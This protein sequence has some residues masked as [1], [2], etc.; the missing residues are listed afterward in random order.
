[1]T[2]IQ[3]YAPK[4]SAG[5]ARAVTAATFTKFRISQKVLD[6]LAK[7]DVVQGNDDTAR[8]PR[9]RRLVQEYG[10]RQDFI[11]PHRMLTRTC[12]ALEKPAKLYALR[13]CGGGDERTRTSD[14]LHAKQETRENEIDEKAHQIADFPY[15]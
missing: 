7:S 6:R 8:A 14:P 12:R 1:V 3:T 15:R 4:C 13:V 2:L 9:A 10:L 5:I 11:L